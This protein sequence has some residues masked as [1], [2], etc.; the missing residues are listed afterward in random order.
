MEAVA[1]A[2]I[3]GMTLV[4]NGIHKDVLLCR[5][6][7]TRT[8]S[9]RRTNWSESPSPT[10]KHNTFITILFCT[11]KKNKIHDE[12]D[13]LFVLSWRPKFVMENVN[14]EVKTIVITKANIL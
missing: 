6:R 7:L 8:P 2:A 1:L 10:D 9:R 12:K 4:Q 14:C 13:L 3:L 5:A 11:E